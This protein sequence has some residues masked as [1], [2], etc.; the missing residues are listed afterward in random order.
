MRR[1][2]KVVVWWFVGG[3]VVSTKSNIYENRII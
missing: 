3:V 2:E 1:S